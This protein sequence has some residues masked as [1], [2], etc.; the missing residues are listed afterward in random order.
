MSSLLKSAFGANVF[1]FDQSAR[2]TPAAVIQ[3]QPAKAPPLE[4]RPSL[5]LLTI[6]AQ[7]K[8][9]QLQRENPDRDKMVFRDKSALYWH[10]ENAGTAFGAYKN[11]ELVSMILMS[12]EDT[13]P[14]TV[15]ANLAPSALKGKH[16][17]IGGAVVAKDFR[18]LGLCQEMIMSCIQDARLNNIRHLHARVRVGNEKSLE[19]FKRAGFSVLPQ[20]GPSPS[21]P[22]HTVHFLHMDLKALKETEIQPRTAKLYQFNKK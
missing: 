20:T 17:V 7:Y 18:N 4:G 10:F 8:M 11:G 2:R 6:L 3:I 19:T 21:D 13:L 16:A 15:K 1:P 22:R 14:A 9:I 5:S 12:E